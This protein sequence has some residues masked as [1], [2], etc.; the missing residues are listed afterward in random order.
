[1]NI[2]QARVLLTGAGGGIGRAM[3]LRL[4]DA[5]AQVFGVGRGDAPAGLPLA[6]WLSVCL[7]VCLSICLLD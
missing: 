1:M 4:A 6:G 2:A 5:G 7:F 3:V